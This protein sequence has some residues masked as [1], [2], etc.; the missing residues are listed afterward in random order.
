MKR[1][2]DSLG[3]RASFTV[4]AELAAGRGYRIESVKAFL[5]EHQAS[6]GG[7]LP[8][9]FD[10]AGIALPQNPGGVSNLEPGDVHAQL[11]A[12][13]LLK[14]LDCIPHI[15]C[16]DHNRAALHSMLAGYRQRGIQTVL[17]LTGD[18]PVSAR[19][20]F[21]LEAIK[22]T[23]LQSILT[24]AIDSVID[25][26]AFNH[27]LEEEHKDSVFLEGIRHSVLDGLREMGDEF[28][29]LEGEAE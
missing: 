7:D 4:V 15:S 25:V 17:A 21:E 14:G 26:E 12:A 8:A 29:F 16:K 27:E 13:G 2:K 23:P 11:Q 24:D 5:E 20:V 18:K 3:S 6:A 1:L 22:G 10:F 9:C 19:G 28:D